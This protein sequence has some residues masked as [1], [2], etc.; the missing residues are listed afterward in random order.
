MDRWLVR[1]ICVCGLL[2][3]TPLAQ[4]HPISISRASVY[5]TRERATVRIEV[6]LEGTR[7]RTGKMLMP[8]LGLLAMIVDAW[9][10]GARDDVQL[11][12]VSIGYERIIE[13]RSYERE[14]SGSAKQAEDLGGLLRT[15]SVFR[16]RYGR[17]HLQFGEPISLAEVAEG[18]GLAQSA[19]VEN[20]NAEC[21]S[22]SNGPN[23]TATGNWH[24]TT[25]LSDEDDSDNIGSWMK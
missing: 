23:K 12:P 14:L 13:A 6:F 17:I 25:N 5:L 18:A 9:R 16:S 2:T 4:A 3:A 19:D 10:S 15:T 22:W 24:I 21:K 20:D 8:K 11:V 1:M 7:S